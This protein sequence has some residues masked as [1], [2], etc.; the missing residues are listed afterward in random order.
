[1]VKRILGRALTFLLLICLVSPQFSISP[2]KAETS[3]APVISISPK[4]IPSASP[5]SPETTFISV[6]WKCPE[7]ETYTVEIV[8]P[9]LI[10]EADK[11]SSIHEFKRILRD[12]R[13]G[14]RA[15]S[16]DI[17]TLM[18]PTEYPGRLTLS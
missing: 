12:S 15:G 8:L 4:S 1:M 14:G 18:P 6:A 13:L 10:I 2:L 11:R 9:K 3:K 7:D 16:R 17:S 5:H